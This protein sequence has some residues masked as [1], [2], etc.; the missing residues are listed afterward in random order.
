MRIMHYQFECGFDKPTACGIKHPIKSG[1]R[2][3]VT[4]KR[5]RR[6]KKFIDSI[7]PTLCRAV[8]RCAG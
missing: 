2:E 8:H 6:T 5:C 4:C 1:Y 7:K 3:L